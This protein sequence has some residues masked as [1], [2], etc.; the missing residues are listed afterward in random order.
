MSSEVEEFEAVLER[1]AGRYGAAFAEAADEHALREANARFVGPQGELTLVLKLMPKLPGPS[2]KTYGQKA[3]AL[4]TA[5]TEAFDA[6]LAGLTWGEGKKAQ[7]KVLDVEKADGTVYP[8]RVDY[9]GLEQ[10]NG[11]PCHHV[12]LGL[13]DFRRAFGPKYDYRYATA[14]GARYLRHD[15]DDLTFTAP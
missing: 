8:M 10:C 15:G 11:A 14:P 12:R 5:V 13:G 7:F 6:R 9:E 3:N 2:R 4:K 1:V